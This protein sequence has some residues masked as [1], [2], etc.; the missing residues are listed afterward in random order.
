MSKRRPYI[1]PSESQA[2][3][4][5]QVVFRRESQ[6]SLPHDA[7]VRVSMD[8]RERIPSDL[9]GMV[10]AVRRAYE[11]EVPTKLHEGPD[12]IGEGGTPKM[13][14][15]A[16]RYLDAPHA[17]DAA[18]GE[19][20]LASYHLTPF[21]AALDRMERGDVHRKRRAAI[22]RHIT[23]GGQEPVTAAIME[24]AHPLDARIVAEDALRVFLNSMTDVKLDTRPEVAA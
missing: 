4:N 23:I 13:T 8:F 22:V 3:A 18:P 17:T 6:W 5:A 19:R 14:D 15:Q 2:A 7:S 10:R 9:R 16:L 21:R 24:Q 11:D 12:N 20:A 1:G